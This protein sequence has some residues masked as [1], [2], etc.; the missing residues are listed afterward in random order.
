VRVSSKETRQILEAI[1]RTPGYSVTYRPQRAKV[2]NRVT[3]A[4]AWIKTGASAYYAN[5]I[6][7]DLRRI[8]WPPEPSITQLPAPHV[9]V[10]VQMTPEEWAEAYAVDVADVPAIATPVEPEPPRKEEPMPTE[11]YM[12]PLVGSAQER[13][14][15]LLVATLK[16]AN[17]ILTAD[18]WVERAIAEH[19]AHGLTVSTWRARISTAWL[20]AEAGDEWL[21]VHRE[22]RPSRYW[23]DDG[24]PREPT[25]RLTPAERREFHDAMEQASFDPQEFVEVGR[26]TLIG[27]GPDHAVVL[28]ELPNDELLIRTA[29]GRVW[30][31]APIERRLT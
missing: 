6:A 10:E 4:I 3:G 23:Y 28:A 9:E 14:Q 24:D 31:A 13:I 1:E 18:E 12:R 19:G 15:H 27:A 5:D 8:G 20:Y 22:G 17:D 16:A 2:L 30:V 25:E 29:D 11:S 26:P 21:H 7:R